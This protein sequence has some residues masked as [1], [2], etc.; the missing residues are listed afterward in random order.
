MQHENLVS[1]DP[2]INTELTIESED[3]QSLRRVL[4][5]IGI[6]LT[7]DDYESLAGIPDNVGESGTNLDSLVGNAE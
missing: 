7:A 1:S 5:Q 2:N 4:E 3:L 6:V